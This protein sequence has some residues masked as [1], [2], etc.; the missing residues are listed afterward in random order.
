ML[1]WV[2]VDPEQHLHMAFFSIS[3]YYSTTQLEWLNLDWK[4]WL[5]ICTKIF[6]CMEWSWGALTPKLFKGQL[7]LL[8]NLPLA[9][10]FDFGHVTCF[11]QK[12]MSK[13]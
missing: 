4:G 2:T 13:S 5:E 7:S 10:D 11:A 6:D 12:N 8:T 9:V 1:D 3:K